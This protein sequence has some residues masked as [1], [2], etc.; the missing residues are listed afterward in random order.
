MN[1]THSEKYDLAVGALDLIGEVSARIQRI[2]S[3]REEDVKAM[4]TLAMGLTTAMKILDPD[5]AKE[6]LLKT[7][8][9]LQQMEAQENAPEPVDTTDVS[10]G[11]YL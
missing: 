4:Q 3:I 7:L 9:H 6:Y 10:V 2:G 11:Q 5:R 8:A 1:L